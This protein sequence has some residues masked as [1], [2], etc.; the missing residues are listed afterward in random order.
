MGLSILARAVGVA[1]GISRPRYGVRTGA[2][3][4]LMADAFRVDPDA[5]A[6][7]VQRMTE[8]PRYAERPSPKST[9]W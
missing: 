9:R 3:R 2:A 6:D 5:L 4:C 8:F 7:A 1:G